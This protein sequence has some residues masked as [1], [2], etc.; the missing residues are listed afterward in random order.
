MWKNS[1]RPESADKLH[2]QIF[3]ALNSRLGE[4]FRFYTPLLATLTG[5]GYVLM[6]ALSRIVF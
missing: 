6:K 5:F 4:F 1:P 2:E 3:N